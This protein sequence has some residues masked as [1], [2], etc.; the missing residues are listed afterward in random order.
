MVELDKVTV[1]HQ[2]LRIL[3]TKKMKNHKNNFL[4][5]KFSYTY[6]LFE[7][8]KFIKS[9]MNDYCLTLLSKIIKY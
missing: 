3:E 9:L 5:K 7:L 2:F 8:N 6:K 1:M 4:Y